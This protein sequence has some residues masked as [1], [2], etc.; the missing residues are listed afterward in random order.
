MQIVQQTEYHFL[1]AKD[2]NTTSMN[3]PNISNPNTVHRAY[4]ST[5]NTS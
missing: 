3:S 2:D 1:I 5:L 4:I